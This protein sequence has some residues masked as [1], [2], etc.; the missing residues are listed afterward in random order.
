[1][2]GGISDGIILGCRSGSLDDRETLR[3]ELAHALADHFGVGARAPRWL[4]EGLAG[5]LGPAPSVTAVATMRPRSW[6][7]RGPTEVRYPPG[8]HPG[9]TNA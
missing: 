3:H 4:T 1:V 2:R 7:R 8:T 6:R 9:K 5:Y